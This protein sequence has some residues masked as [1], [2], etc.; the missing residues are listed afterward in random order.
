MQKVLI[1][2]ENGTL[3][4][5][6]HNQL[7]RRE[8]EIAAYTR[9]QLDVTQKQDVKKVTELLQPNIIFHCAAK[10]DVD[11]CEN[12]PKQ[13]YLVNTLS[14]GFVVEAAK[15]IGAIVVFP[16][17]YYVYAGLNVDVIDDR[18]HS[19]ELSRITAVYS[20]HKL[21]AEEYIKKFGY[22]KVFIVRLG[23]LFGGGKNDKKFV[24]KI[25]N[26]AK[27]EEKIPVVT[28]RY[29]QPTYVKDIVKNIFSLLDTKQYGTY[30]MVAHGIASF[31]EYAQAVLMYSKITSVKLIPI[32]ANSYEEFAP[33]SQ[34]L[35][36]I[37]GKLKVLGLDLMRDWR[38]ALNEY[39]TE[40]VF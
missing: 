9:T 6:L 40:T 22:S 17:T 36:A 35:Y 33:R 3:A 12:H 15:R 1:T 5:E 16:S 34:K 18:I 37:N 23:S 8:I 31:F 10:T 38:I 24:G 14:A 2:G 26:L 7:K 4:S 11:W 30:N 39:L 28:D 29:I 20:K 21:L 32:L 27:S 13:S 25:L 19:P